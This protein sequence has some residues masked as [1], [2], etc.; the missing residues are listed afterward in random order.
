MSLEL[1]ICELGE[2]LRKIEEKYKLEVLVK[3]NLSGGW[4]TITGEAIIEKV[5]K[6]KKTS[7]GGGNGDN[8]IDIKIKTENNEDGLIMKITG[9]KNKK[10]I[11]DVSS[12]RY[13][14]IRPNNLSIN[15]TKINEN[16][17]KLRIDE[18]I[19]FSIKAP[20]DEVIQIIEG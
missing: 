7:C 3:S 10:F 15:Q 14:E 20:A 5:P 8:I 18:N 2:A 9:A 17:S 19:I 12:A 6:D 16:E 11:I 1:N 13:K 4:M